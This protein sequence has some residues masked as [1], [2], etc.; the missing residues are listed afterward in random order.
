MIDAVRKVA[1]SIPVEHVVVDLEHEEPRSPHVLVVANETVSGGRCSIETLERRSR[2]LAAPLHVIVCPQ[3][4]PT[5]SEH[6]EA[7]AAARRALAVLRGEGL[8][9]TGSRAP[10][11]VTSLSCMRCTTSGWTRS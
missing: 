5:Q 11:P 8:D 6:P 10:R 4:G 1:G 2:A 3:S 9:V 7:A